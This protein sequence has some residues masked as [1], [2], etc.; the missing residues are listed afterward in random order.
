MS[1][2]SYARPLTSLFLRYAIQIQIQQAATVTEVPMQVHPQGQGIIA[3]SGGQN[4]KSRMEWGVTE[5]GFWRFVRDFRVFSEGWV[6]RRALQHAFTSSVAPA[7]A[8]AANS[9]SAG[10]RECYLLYPQ[11]VEALGRTVSGRNKTTVGRR[12]MSLLSAIPLSTDSTLLCS[13]FHYSYLQALTMFSGPVFD[14]EYRNA[15]DK[16]V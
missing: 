4:M 11:F 6:E 9:D 10:S 8:D 13:S 3:A 2:T 15:R 5:D 14:A 7:V 1:N 12:D 16:V